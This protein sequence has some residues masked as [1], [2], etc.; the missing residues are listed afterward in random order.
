M[1]FTKNIKKVRKNS[2]EKNTNLF[3]CLPEEN[4]KSNIL[5]NNYIIGCSIVKEF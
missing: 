5:E 2:E 1:Y 3:Y 4:K